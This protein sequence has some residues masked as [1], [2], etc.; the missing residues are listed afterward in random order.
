MRAPKRWLMT[1]GFACFGVAV[2]AYS[3]ALRDSLGGPAWLAAAVAGLATLGA[4][5]CRLDTSSTV[6]RIHRGCAMVGSSSL[7]LT[8]V[9]AAQALSARGLGRAAAASC[10]VGG[11]SGVCLAASAFASTEGLFQ[12]VGLLLAQGWLVASAVTIARGLMQPI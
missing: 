11:L 10:L 4:G 1:A 6:D 7:A 5:A 9:F 8:P 2:P 3:V 12:R